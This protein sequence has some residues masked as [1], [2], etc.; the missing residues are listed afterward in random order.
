M[1]GVI[2]GTASDE[3]LSNVPVLIRS[4]GRPKRSPLGVYQHSRCLAELSVYTNH[5]R[6]LPSEQGMPTSCR[7]LRISSAWEITPFQA[8]I[9]DLACSYRSLCAHPREFLLFG[10][11]TTRTDLVR[12]I[13]PPSSLQFLPRRRPQGLYYRFSTRRCRGACV[14]AYGAGRKRSHVSKSPTAQ[15]TSLRVPWGRS[16]YSSCD[17]ERLNGLSRELRA[18]FA[19]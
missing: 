14:A 16:Y 13:P 1:G 15:P 10:H 18:C 5:I 12:L 11:K 2:E 6:F 7:P 8:C 17:V 19:G 3:L 9:T 4:S